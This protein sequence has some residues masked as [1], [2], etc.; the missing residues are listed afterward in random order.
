MGYL[1][2]ML[3]V[4]GLLYRYN[5]LLNSMEGKIEAFTKSHDVEYQLLYIE[6]IRKQK[7]GGLNYD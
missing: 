7:Y 1:C 2:V 6:D 4:C 3:S 5:H